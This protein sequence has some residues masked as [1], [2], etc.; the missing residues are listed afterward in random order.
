MAVTST[1]CS[2]GCD[3]ARYLTVGGQPM[4]VIYRIEHIPQA[5]AAVARLKERAVASGMTGLHVFA[6]I[7]SRDFENLPAEVCEVLDGLV[8]F[9]P[10]SGISLQSIKH[11]APDLV[12]D[13]SG[14]IY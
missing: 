7:P 9:P 5:R 12:A 10:G 14:D 1:T 4:L 11:L 13:A 2:R 3:V 8:R 6:V